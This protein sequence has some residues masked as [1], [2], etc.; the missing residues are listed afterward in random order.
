MEK[1]TRTGTEN[2]REYIKEFYHIKFTNLVEKYDKNFQKNVKGT[3][4]LIAINEYFLNK[5]VN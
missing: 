4:A 5:E 2:L 1:L 3:S